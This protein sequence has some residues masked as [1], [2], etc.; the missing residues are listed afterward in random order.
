MELMTLVGTGVIELLPIKI[1][2]RAYTDGEVEWGAINIELVTPRYEPAEFWPTNVE[3]VLFVTAVPADSP[4][5]V[6]TPPPALTVRPA[7]LPSA[8]F[9]PAPAP[10]WRALL[11]TAV[12]PLKELPPADSP[13]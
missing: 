1:A 7:Y 2:S 9:C 11:P 6:F 12:F 5:N 3:P 13:N 10:F 8:T 4:M